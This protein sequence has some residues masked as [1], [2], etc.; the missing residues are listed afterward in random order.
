[1]IARK[2]GSSLSLPSKSNYQWHSLF[3]GSDA[4]SFDYTDRN[5]CFNC[6]YI[7]G[8]YGYTNST[9]TLMGTTARDTVI[10]L[11]QNRPQVAAIEF[12]GDMLY[13]S[14]IISSSEADM[15]VTLTSLDSGIADLYVAV[16]NNTEYMNAERV[17]NYMLPDPDDSTS[18]QYTTA[19]TQDD[20]VFI[21]GPHWIESIVVIAVRAESYIGVKFSIVAT[22]SQYPVLLLSGVPQNH[23]VEFGANEFFK[24]YPHADA[25][26]R[27]SLT[28]KVIFVC[29]LFAS[30]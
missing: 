9:Y 8:V 14:C 13:F 1:M 16:Y 2:P 28:G 25:D 10:K 3:V 11:T 19:H 23:F 30:T 29:S 17:D 18:Y 21:P 22:S 12:Q 7:I 15:S 26:L 27:V 20:H 6:E 5:Y 4:V 24:Y